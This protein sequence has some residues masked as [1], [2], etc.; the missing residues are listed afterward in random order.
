MARPKKRASSAAPPG[1]DPTG[2]AVLEHFDPEVHKITQYEGFEMVRIHRMRINEATYNP[3]VISDRARGRL[4][5]GIKTVKLV[6]P[7]VWNK[8]T[9]NLVSGH[10]RLRVIDG[11]EHKRD[12]WLTVAQIDVDLDT[13]VE[14]NLLLNNPEAQGAF[15]IGKLHQLVVERQK[16]L[17][18]EATGFGADDMYSMFGYKA[19][20]GD[21]GAEQLDKLADDLRD[22]REAYERVVN[23][24]KNS[25]EACSDRTAG[26]DY[27]VV[28]VFQ[29]G[30]DRD[31]FLTEVYGAFPLDGAHWYL[32]GRDL[33]RIFRAR[34]TEE[35][36]A[37]EDEGEDDEEYIRVTTEDG[38]VVAV[39]LSAVRELDEEEGKPEE[40]AAVEAPAEGTTDAA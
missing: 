21:E 2:A 30:K 32:D 28:A 3:R 40:D 27:Y 19:F 9:G 20:H 33:R 25:Q 12:Y 15:D 10:Q 17:R 34:T 22:K 24:A 23:T 39:P 26:E 31:A 35:A 13:E 5:D 16:P 1:A 18:L 7:L 38:R 8:R 6:S 11:L 14:I 29:N 37:A 36:L 4:K